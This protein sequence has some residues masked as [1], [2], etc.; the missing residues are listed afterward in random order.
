MS[1][2][3]GLL[4][5]SRRIFEFQKILNWIVHALI[6]LVLVFD[7]GGIFGINLSFYKK[8]LKMLKSKYLLIKSGVQ[9]FKKDR[10]S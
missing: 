8:Y 6:A 9:P 2:N 1:I 5:I 7:Y 10:H 4:N 3:P